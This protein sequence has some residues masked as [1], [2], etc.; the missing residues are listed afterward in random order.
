MRAAAAP[1]GAVARTGRPILIQLAI[2]LSIALHLV[3]LAAPALKHWQPAKPQGAPALH[4]SVLHAP[5]GERPKQPDVL[6]QADS[7]GGGD[8]TAGARASAPPAPQALQVPAEAGAKDADAR[9]QRLTRP[10]AA[11]SVDAGRADPLSADTLLAQARE[12]AVPE[13]GERAERFSPNDA[14]P[15]RGVFGVNAY[16]VEWARYVEDW[17]IKIERVGRL[18]YPDEARRQGLF[19][20]LQLRVVVGADGRLLSVD[21]TRSSG[22]ALLDDAAVRIVR[23]SAPFAP[24]PPAL[25][26]KF[27][28]LQ[29]A[30]KWSF[31]TDNSLAGG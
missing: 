28:S 3:F 31:T 9:P 15:K 1:A 30:R 6:A 8:A 20:S 7:A 2:A 12:L 16:G 22:H 24:F 4:V 26:A 10:Q 11:H 27:S 19:G 5:S 21:V 25:A 29:I 14:A 13:V 17:R 23:M 18:N